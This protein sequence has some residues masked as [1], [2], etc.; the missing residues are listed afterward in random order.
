MKIKITLA[1]L[2]WSGTL[3]AL[4]PN[5]AAAAPL[6]GLSQSRSVATV[7]NPSLLKVHRW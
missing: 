7:D 5:A 6:S 2:A 1:A 4:L 3:L